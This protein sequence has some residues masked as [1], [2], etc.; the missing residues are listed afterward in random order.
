MTLTNE[1]LFNAL[2]LIA[3][4]NETLSISITHKKSIINTNTI[5][6]ALHR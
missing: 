3:L 4:I 5:R 2:D 1:V 6:F